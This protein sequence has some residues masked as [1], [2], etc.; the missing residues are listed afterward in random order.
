MGA[1]IFVAAVGFLINGVDGVAW[2]VVIGVILF[3][4]IASAIDN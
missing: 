3:G 1:L 2:A 4:W